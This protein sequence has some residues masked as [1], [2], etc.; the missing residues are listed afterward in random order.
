M[1]YG[2]TGRVAASYKDRR[3]CKIHRDE[4]RE[5]KRSTT[6][7]SPPAKGRRTDFD[8]GEAAA[9]VNGGGGSGFSPVRCNRAA[10]SE[11]RVWWSC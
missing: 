5:G 8:D 11:A 3:W 9:G 10:A 1:M 7:S 4:E 2:S 6:A